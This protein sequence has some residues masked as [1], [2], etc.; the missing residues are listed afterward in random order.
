MLIKEA[1]LKEELNNIKDFLN[2]FDLSMDAVT[3]TIYAEIDD[4]IVGTVSCNNDIIKCLAV[5]PLY[6]SE[7]V[8]NLL[9]TEIINYLNSNNIYSYLVFTKPMYDKVFL[10]LGFRKIIMDENV[11]L[12]EGG[13]E[14][15]TDKINKI[16]TQIEFSIGSLNDN[17]DLAAIVINANPITIGHEHLIET[18]SK[19]HDYVVVFVVEEDKSIFKFDERLSMVY[20]TCKRLNNVVVVPSSKYIVSQLTFPTYFLKEDLVEKEHAM[21]DALIFRD[22][23]C[24]ILPIKKRYL[25]KET[26]KKMVSYNTILKEVLGDKIIEIDRLKLDNEIVS[27]SFVRMLL[28][29]HQYEECLKYIPKQIQ[30]VF[31]MVAKSHYE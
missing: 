10:S 2:K 5:D 24:K 29:N 19:N 31:M 26:K 28:E 4:K 30:T 6:Q 13:N 27:A 17:T 15:I 14:R 1:L 12:L 16:K 23:F 9:I 25:G 18:A 20:L 22:Y 21:I 8:S 11:I 3:H 7:N